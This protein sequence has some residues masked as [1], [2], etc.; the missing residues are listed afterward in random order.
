MK[1]NKKDLQKLIK[2]NYKNYKKIVF[3]Q[4]FFVSL[5]MGEKVSLF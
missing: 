4:F 1:N 5:Q 3:I 2:K